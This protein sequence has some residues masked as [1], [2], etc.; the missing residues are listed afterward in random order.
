MPGMATSKMLQIERT[1]MSIGMAKADSKINIGKNVYPA[2][3]GRRGRGR[4]RS[5]KE[6]EQ[7]EEAKKRVR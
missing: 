4:R 1:K 2:Q 7:G 5:K 3:K 6:E